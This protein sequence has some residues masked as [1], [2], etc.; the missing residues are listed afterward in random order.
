MSITCR[1][2]LELDHP[3]FID[4]KWNGGCK[5]CPHTYGYKKMDECVCDCKTCDNDICTK[6]WDQPYEGE[7][8]ELEKKYVE[9][10]HMRK[11]YSSLL[12]AIYDVWESTS[13]VAFRTYAPLC[14]DPTANYKAK[15]FAMGETISD[16]D[17]AY[18]NKRSE[19]DEM[20]QSRNKWRAAW[21]GL[22]GGYIIA[23]LGFIL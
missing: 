10:R 1:E 13:G 18:K 3:E 12:S 22:L 7:L 23:I 6:C 15:L 17:T 21:W 14:F 2:K 8:T 16:L 9:L 4:E 11:A 5:D 20:E 19:C